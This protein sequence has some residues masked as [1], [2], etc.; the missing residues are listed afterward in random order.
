MPNIA[1]GIVDGNF[2]VVSL[3]RTRAGI[4]LSSSAL[5]SVPD[6]V[7]VPSF[8]SPNVQDMTQLV[9]IITQTAEAAGLGNKRR[10][11]AVVP[12]NAIRTVIVT[13]E[14]KPA[15]RHELNEMISWKTERSIGT[16][17]SELRI[18]KQKL[19][20]VAGQDRY[21]VAAARETILQ[22]YES[23]FAAAGWQTGLLLPKYLGETQ[24]LISADPK[25][26]KMLVSSNSNGFTSVVIK[27][28][29]VVLVRSHECD[30]G[31]VSDE[32]YRVALY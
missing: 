23:A 3:R 27:N 16:P 32:L 4:E 22:E 5:T 31:S 20:R 15:N 11:S 30:L 2:V 29:E 9:Q 26:P 8:D 6:E 13:V 24:W 21:L 28:G 25:T 12:D 17:S 7:L 19:T 10:W 18:S 1:A 14:G